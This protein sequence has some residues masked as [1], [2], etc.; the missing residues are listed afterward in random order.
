MLQGTPKSGTPQN[1]FAVNSDGIPESP[2]S[3]LFISSPGGLCSPTPFVFPAALL[4]T[5]DA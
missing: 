4:P 3:P 1:T 5:L 2:P